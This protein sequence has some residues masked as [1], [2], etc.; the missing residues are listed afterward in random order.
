MKSRW[1]RFYIFPSLDGI[2]NEK[3]YDFCVDLLKNAGVACV[4]GSAFGEMGEGY[5]RLSYCNSI[6]ELEKRT[7]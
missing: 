4:P 6:D 1:E 7:S 5:M 2:T 3:S